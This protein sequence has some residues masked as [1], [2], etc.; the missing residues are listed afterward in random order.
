MSSFNQFIHDL[1][2]DSDDSDDSSC[3]D[4]LSD[5]ENSDEYN[6]PPSPLSQISRISWASSF[7]RNNK[8]KMCWS[9]LMFSWIL[10]PAKLFLSILFR[11]SHFSF[12]YWPITYAAADNEI[13][14]LMNP[15]NKVNALK[16]HIIHRATDRRRGI[17]EV[18]QPLQ[19]FLS[20]RYFA[21]ILAEKNH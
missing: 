3:G 5:E 11:L 13:S 14:S 2:V 7:S 10:L 6:S 21:L 15:V 16:D 8:W 4:D 19:S 9:T 18:I 12:S 1:S 20:S 17:V